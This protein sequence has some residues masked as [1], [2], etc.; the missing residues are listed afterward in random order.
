MYL[1]TLRQLYMV[2]R[3]AFRNRGFSGRV[4]WPAL[5]WYGSVIGLLVSH[6]PMYTSSALTLPCIRSMWAHRDV[7]SRTR[8]ALAL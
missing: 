7:A 2:C 4:C 5:Q 1:S 8:R 6:R 3:H